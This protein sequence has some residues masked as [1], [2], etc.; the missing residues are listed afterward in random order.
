[1]DKSARLKIQLPY[2]KGVSVLYS[3]SSYSRLN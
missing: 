3:K 2:R 1:M